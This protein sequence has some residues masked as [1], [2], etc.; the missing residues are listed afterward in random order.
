M[1]EERWTHGSVKVELQ[2]VRPEQV[3]ELRTW[4]DSRERQRRE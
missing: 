4:R 3:L 2:G 1:A